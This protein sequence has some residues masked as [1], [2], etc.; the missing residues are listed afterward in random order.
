MA[1]THSAHRIAAVALEQAV[2][3][4]ANPRASRE[5]SM[6]ACA[7][8]LSSSTRTEKVS[9]TRR[10][11]WGGVA[12]ILRRSARCRLTGRRDSA[13]MGSRQQELPGQPRGQQCR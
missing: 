4:V 12:S 5:S 9:G 2:L 11:Q 6:G 3:L 8:E 7:Q 1:V 13:A 10:E